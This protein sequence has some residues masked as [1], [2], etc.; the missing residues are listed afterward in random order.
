MSAQQA[1]RPSPSGAVPSPQPP[2][3]KRGWGLGIKFL[4]LLALML[5][6]VFGSLA[7]LLGTRSGLVAA[8][9]LGTR[10]TAGALQVEG[11]QGRLLGPLRADR[12]RYHAADLRPEIEA[13]EVLWQP[14]LLLER[15]LLID[16]LAVAHIDFAQRPTD[17][18]A[19]P[20]TAPDSLELPLA[21]ELRQLEV[22]RFALP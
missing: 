1:S 19:E 15:R 16:R 5:C 6:L 17:E 14:G 10:A 22:G 4:L 11:A 21:L 18:P 20:L 2:A 9:A 13:V 8:I 7:W 3:A 12:V